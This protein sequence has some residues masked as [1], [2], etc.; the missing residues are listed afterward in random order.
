MNEQFV[1]LQVKIVSYFVDAKKHP[2]TQIKNKQQATTNEA[3]KN[4]GIK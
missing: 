2:M 3:F 1:G 4:F